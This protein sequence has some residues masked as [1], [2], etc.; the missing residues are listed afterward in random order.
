MFECLNVVC[1]FLVAVLQLHVVLLW[2]H[3]MLHAVVDVCVVCSKLCFVSVLTDSVCYH[4]RYKC[5]CCK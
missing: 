1:A 2:Y 3:I 4:V 5:M